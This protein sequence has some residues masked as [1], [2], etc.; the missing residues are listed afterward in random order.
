MAF[1]TFD[2]LHAGHEYYL[3]QAKQLGDNLIVVVA[4]DRTVR[5]VKGEN[6]LNNERKRL[7]ALK[8]S[9][10]A[11]KVIL[12]D[13]TDKYKVV[14]KY[15]PGAIALGYDQLVFT[16]KLNKTFIDLN[17][18]TRIVRMDAYFP[19]VYK[20]SLLK[21]RITSDEKIETEEISHSLIHN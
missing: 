7:N 2:I 5:Q 3:K 6:P 13:L 9:G 20:S 14:R 16:Q 10:I 12:G 17:M 15:R 21:K 1:G 4:R 11:D 18:D 19:Q 8:K